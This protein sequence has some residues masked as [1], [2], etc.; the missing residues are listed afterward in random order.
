MIKISKK[1][2]KFP[3]N[4]I[5]NCDQNFKQTKK[6]KFQ[7]NIIEN[8]GL[9]FLKRTQNFQI[10]YNWKWWSKLKKNDKWNEYKNR[11]KLVNNIK[12]VSQKIKISRQK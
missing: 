2:R 9:S 5:E 11:L 1:K 7:K 8:C 10:K 3:K 12:N 4:I 6:E